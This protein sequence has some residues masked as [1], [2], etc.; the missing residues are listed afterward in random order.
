MQITLHLLILESF[1][2]SDI[3]FYARRTSSHISFEHLGVNFLFNICVFW[4][5][6]FSAM[7]P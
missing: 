3:I 5:S 7:R 4:D 2:L 1:N 6:R